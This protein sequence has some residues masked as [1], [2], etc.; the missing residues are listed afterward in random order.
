MKQ[1]VIVDC[2]RT[3]MGRSKAGIFRNVRAE[4]LSA[5]VMAALVERNPALDP[6]EID[7][8]IWGCVQQTLEQGLTWPVTHRYW[9]AFRIQCRL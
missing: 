5:Y 9:Q 3:P 4:E 8:I 6:A 1:A 2:I 7:D